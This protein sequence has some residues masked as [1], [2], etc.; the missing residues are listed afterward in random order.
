MVCTPLNNTVIQRSFLAS[1]L[2]NS[3]VFGVR[4]LYNLNSEWYWSVE[5]LKSFVFICV[6]VLFVQECFRVN[7]N[8]V[9]LSYTDW[10]GRAVHLLNRSIIFKSIVVSVLTQIVNFNVQQYVLSIAKRMGIQQTPLRKLMMEIGVSSVSSLLFTTIMY[11]EWALIDARDTVLSILV[12]AWFSI[13]IMLHVR[14]ACL[15]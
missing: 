6:N 13:V 7:D 1:L 3:I 12:M 10:T 11:F 14:P 2:I 15:L 8:I 5:Q 9:K 4:Y